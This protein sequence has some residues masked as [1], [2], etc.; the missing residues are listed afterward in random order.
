MRSVYRL[1]LAGTALVSSF[2]V[3]SLLTWFSSN[4][5]GPI[6][7][8]LDLLGA[9]VGSIEHGIRQSL[10]RGSGR[11]SGLAWFAPYRANADLLLHPDTVLLGAYDSALPETLDGVVDLERVIGS[12]LPLVHV[13]IGWGDKPEAHF[14]LRLATAIWDMG[15]VPVI[16][17]EPWLTEFE[18][19]RHPKLPL[20]DA[21]DRHGMA[22]VA[23][24]DY[25]FYIDT[26]AADVARFGRPLFLRFGHEM[27]DAYRYP[28]GPQ[29]NT[30]EEYIAAWRHVWE[31]FR[32]A[33]ARNAIWT[34]SPH[35]AY[36]DWDTYYPG[37]GYVDW[38]ATGALNYGA[39]GQQ[40]TQW[41]SF[42]DIF[43]SKYRR[44]ASFGKPV[45]IAEF[46]SLAV[47]GNRVAWYRDALTAFPKR[48][49]AVKALL[50]FH[51]KSDRTVTYQVLDWS[52][53]RD[54]ALSRAIASAVKDWVPSNLEVS[55][56]KNKTSSQTMPDPIA[57]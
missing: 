55:R 34:W 50:F 39:L 32:L 16:T 3:I 43:G 35:V 5:E 31:R 51:S 40:W 56:V 20:R 29:N 15:S 2:A 19:T 26:W 38:V 28:W 21:R 10:D 42:E 22:A 57:R 11:S 17:W 49:P 6:A 36:A 18:N 24:G 1:A 37:S 41:W 52:V 53:E 13:Y 9:S 8:G 14:P 7:S 44:L 25:D 48:Y 12:T 27:N 47:G 4:S 23:H 54:P 46:G 33:G 30:S 45:M